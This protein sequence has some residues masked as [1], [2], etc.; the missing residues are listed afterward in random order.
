LIGSPFCALT[1]Q[2]DGV[3]VVFISSSFGGEDCCCADTSRPKVKTG[4]HCKSCIVVKS[5]D[6]QVEWSRFWTSGRGLRPVKLSFCFW[7][8]FVSDATVQFLASRNSILHFH[9]SS[10]TPHTSSSALHRSRFFIMVRNRL[11]LWFLSMW[12]SISAFSFC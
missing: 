4:I 10:S 2:S 8:L 12:C 1:A 11:M 7:G 6:Y 9:P 3:Y 5:S